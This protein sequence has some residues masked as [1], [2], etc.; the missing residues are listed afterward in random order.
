MMHIHLLSQDEAYVDCIERGHHV[1]MRAATGN[2]PSVPKTRHEW[3]DPDIEQLPDYHEIIENPMDFGTLRRKLDA[4]LYSNL[5]QLEVSSGLITKKGFKGSFGEAGKSSK[6]FA[7]LSGVHSLVACL[8]KRLRGKDDG[9]GLITKKGFKGSFGEA[10][11][12]TKTFA[13]LS[14]V[15]S[16]VACLL[17]RLRGK[18]DGSGLIT[19]KG[20]KGSFGEA[21]KSAK[22]FTILSGVHSLVACLLKRLRGKDDG[23][24][25]A[26]AAEDADEQGHSSNDIL[27]VIVGTKSNSL[28]R[29]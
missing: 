19:K 10:G 29:Q 23:K 25:S 6:T 7:I 12:S 14:R 20:F 2:E 9:F 26:K 15:H 1:P 16:L 11:K 13:I 21:G 24:A 3:S 27:H 17:K 22:T 28:Y 18:D 4:G 8:L 5:E